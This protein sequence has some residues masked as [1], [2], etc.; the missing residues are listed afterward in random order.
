MLPALRAAFT[1]TFII[2]CIRNS[3]KSRIEPQGRTQVDKEQVKSYL[4][5]F[6]ILTNLAKESE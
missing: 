1:A 3:Q 2:G 4:T 6:C 5:K